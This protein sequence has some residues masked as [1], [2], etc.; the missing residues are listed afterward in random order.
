MFKKCPK[1]FKIF[2]YHYALNN[3]CSNRCEIV[4]CKIFFPKVFGFSH[5][6]HLFL[7]FFGFFKKTLAKSLFCDHN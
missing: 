3:S 1:S 7:S 5:F 4:W 6:G 2:Y